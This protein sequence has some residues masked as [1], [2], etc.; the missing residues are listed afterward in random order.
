MLLFID[1]NISIWYQIIKHFTP[2]ITFL[3]KTSYFTMNIVET[4]TVHSRIP[5]HRRLFSVTAS[6]SGSCI[7]DS[8]NI[9]SKNEQ[10]ILEVE[11]AW[12]LARHVILYCR[13]IIKI[14]FYCSRINTFSFISICCCYYTTPI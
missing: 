4:R 1:F 7:P 2:H 10:I 12:L 14:D 13:E 3:N 11:I 5:V 9:T 8:V 6:P